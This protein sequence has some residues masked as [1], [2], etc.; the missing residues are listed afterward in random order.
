MEDDLKY[1]Y[2]WKTTLNIFVNGRQPQ[3]FM[4]MEDNLKYFFK[5]K[6]TLNILVMEDNIKH[7]L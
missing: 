6:S 5:W 7:F 1:F 2:K 4:K 3:I